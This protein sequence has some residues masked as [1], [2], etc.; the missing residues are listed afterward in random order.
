[1]GDTGGANSGAQNRRLI[2][3][4]FLSLSAALLT[5]ILKATAAAV[6]GSVGFL[7]DALESGVNVVAATLGIIALRTAAMPP[8]RDHHFGHGKAEYLSAAAEGS[9]I[10]IASALILWTSVDRLINP[11]E[12]EHTTLGIALSIAA[13]AINLSV[14]VLLVRVGRQSRSLTLEADGKHLLTDVWTSVGVLA[15]IVLVTIFDLDV[16]DPIVALL[17]GV[18]IMRTGYQL[19]KRSLTGLLDAAL[20]PAD[21]AK[22]KAVLDR[23]R[24]TDGIEFAP[25][26][27]RE[28][29]R[30]RF[31][32]VTMRVPGDW[33]V[34]RGHDLADQV[35]H[36]MARELPG[37]VTFTHVE[38]LAMDQP[39][40][41]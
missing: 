29:G 36:E 20:S 6:T 3:F 23:C 19:V 35:E 10:L 40:L 24:G 7:S 5:V 8:D 39:S 22:V 30:Q 27:T 25:V 38:P 31:V 21:S 37:A 13:T 28:S 41:P 17:V 4:M 2:R 9:M 33:S 18:H 32:Y 16:L 26:R 34:K 11:V 14:G 12:I 1:M 15:G